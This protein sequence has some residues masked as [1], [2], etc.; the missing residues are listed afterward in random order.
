MV[1]LVALTVAAAACSA[2]GDAPTAPVG[3]FPQVFSGRGFVTNAQLLKAGAVSPASKKISFHAVAPK[4]GGWALVVRC[5]RGTVRSDFGGGYA[6]LP[7]NGTS[8]LIAG[9]AGG[10]NEH[11]SVTVDQK[12]PQRW[13]I[14]VYRSEFA[15][16]SAAERRIKERGA[17]RE[18]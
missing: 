14:A 3:F 18:P 12:Q 9:C 10:L 5:Y 13:G 1:A 7:C 6:G 16:E 4:S 8:G 15:P 2:S 11:L 17:P